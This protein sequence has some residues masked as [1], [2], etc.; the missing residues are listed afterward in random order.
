MAM[1]GSNL[2]LKLTGVTGESEESNH[3]GEIEVESFSEGLHNMS[4]A[5]TGG[6]QG[7]GRVEYQD[8]SFSCKLEK[9]I[10]AIMK[11]CADG[12]PVFE[13]K[14]CATKVGGSGKSY[15]YLEITLSNARVSSVQVSGGANQLGMVSV[16]MNFEK[17]KTEYWVE[18]ATG[19]QGAGSAAEWSNKEN[20]G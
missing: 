14:F 15:N 6:G 17:I 11:F 19:G 16:S 9:A 18:N 7:V 13:T 2:F 1:Q 12:K 4:S 5:G 10:P 20:R 8:F 3:K